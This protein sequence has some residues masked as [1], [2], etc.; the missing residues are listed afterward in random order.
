MHTI[1]LLL[2]K[3]AQEIPFGP[4][5]HCNLTA[6]LIFLYY[7]CAIFVDFTFYCFC[8]FC[9][10]E[11]GVSCSHGGAGHLF[12]T[13]VDGILQPLLDPLT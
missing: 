11:H 12:T 5:S 10:N 2:C 13:V 3:H 6:K 7:I 8:G 9:S 1:R 4:T